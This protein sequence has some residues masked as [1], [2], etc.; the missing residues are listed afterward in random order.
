MVDQ[1]LASGKIAVPPSSHEAPFLGDRYLASSCMQKSIRRGDVEIARRAAMALSRFDKAMLLRRFAGTICEDVSPV[2]TSVVSEGLLSPLG[3]ADIYSLMERLGEEPKDRSTDYLLFIAQYAPGLND[4]RRKLGEAKDLLKHLPAI[5]GSSDDIA[6]K[7][8]AAWYVAGTA[9]I[10]GANL[11]RTYGNSD[12]VFALFLDLG[13]P[14]E[15]VLGC[16]SSLRRV[17]DPLALFYP[18]IYLETLRGTELSVETVALAPPVIVRGVPLYGAAGNTRIGKAAIRKWIANSDSLRKAL[19]NLVHPQGWQKAAE[20]GLFHAESGLLGK[21]L[22]WELGERLRRD[23]IEAEFLSLAARVEAVW[24]FIAT[25]ASQLSL[26]DDIRADLIERAA[27]SVQ[28]EL[29]LG[30]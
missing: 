6:V 16:K 7:A 26:L 24:D 30:A 29:G 3:D 13:V 1:I 8:L 2:N 25:I 12:D 19:A 4:A 10:P 11:S 27:R 17:R 18:I 28:L 21:A 5:M 22:K 9:Q 15:L 23:G 14:E 20:I